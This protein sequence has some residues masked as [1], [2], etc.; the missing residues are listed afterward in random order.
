MNSTHLIADLYRVIL[1]RKTKNLKNINIIVK[2]IFSSL[3]TELS[4][5]ILFSLRKILFM[6][7]IESKIKM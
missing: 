3:N 7:I 6:Y 4:Y 5:L 1:H 2:P